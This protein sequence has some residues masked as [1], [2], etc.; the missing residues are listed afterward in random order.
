MFCS[1]ETALA[2]SSSKLQD[3]T[4]LEEV[5]I[6]ATRTE[7]SIGDIPVP[8]QVISREFIR[9]T[10]SQKLVDILQQ[11]TGVVLADNPLG[12]AL[13]GYPNPFGSG[14]QLQGLDPAYTLILVDG[15]PL[16]GRNA[17]I[18]NMGRVAI[19]N[20]RQIEIVKGPATSLFGSD[21]L[22]G[23]INI[24]TDKPEKKEGDVQLHHASNNTWGI[25]AGKG[26]SRKKL[27][28]QAFANRLSSSGYD[29]DRSIYGKTSDAF[30]NYSGAVKADY[31]FSEKT[32]L[33]SSFRIFHQRQ[34]NNYLVFTGTEPDPVSGTTIERDWSFNN[35]LTHQFNDKA[36]LFVRLYATGYQNNARVYFDKNDQLYDRSYLEQQLIKPE[37]QFDWGKGKNGKWISGAGAFF[38]TIDASRY[39]QQRSFNA[40]YVFTQKEWLWKNKFNLTIG[41]RFDKHQL[42]ASQ[43][44]PKVAMA[45]K[46]NSK[47][48]LTGSIGTGF[49]APDFR[50]QFLAFNNTVV[51]YSLIGAA[52]LSGQLQQMQQLGQIAST[53]DIS[54]F[55]Q[56]RSLLAEQSVGINFGAKYQINQGIKIEANFFR[57]DIRNLIERYNLPFTR[58]NGQ[59]IFSYINLNRV[60]TTGGDIS[61]HHRITARM[62][63]Q[64]GYQYLEARDKDVVRKIRNNELVQRD[65]FPPFN[66]RFTTMADY[67]GLFNRSRHSGNL[68]LFYNYPQQQLEFSTRLVYR[69]RFGFVDRNGNDVLD[70]DAEYAKGYVLAHFTVTKQFG[71]FFAVQTGIENFLNYT[72]PVT[73]PSLPGRTMFV[74]LNYTLH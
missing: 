49:K 29:L 21:A 74:N 20:I 61:F 42:F 54:P 41:A 53:I 55:T 63:W 69:G 52:E 47:L 14:I 56:P 9:Q 13:Q 26:F 24:I 71:K 60:F 36:T 32:S 16:T 11:Q 15:E 48:R 28:V 45:W 27:N 50:Q 67:G 34:F 6:T 59:A 23:V 12:Q 19:G 31:Q 30:Y 72:D 17:G 46:V 1:A 3:T 58:T 57:N 10:G 18:L 65:P 5:V 35:Q 62:R 70:N 40:Y 4:N 37:I 39:T 7:K 51:G 66:S 33:R 8:I 44:N 73:L 22:A 25:T 64:V 43:F 2:Q 38:E 68:M